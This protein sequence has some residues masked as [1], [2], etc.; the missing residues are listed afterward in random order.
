MQKWTPVLFAFFVLSAFSSTRTVLAQSVQPAPDRSS[1]LDLLN[2]VN[3]LRASH[4]LPPYR[5]NAILMGITQTQADYLASS[6]LITH[7]GADG[8][9]PYQRALAAGY[10]L[11]GDVS[12][13][14]YYSENVAAATNMTAADAVTMWMGDAPHQNTMLSTTYQDAGVGMAVS[15]NIYYYALD[16]GLSTGGTAAPYIPPTQSV[17]AS[18]TPGGATSTQGG[19]ATI[20]YVVKSGDTLYGIAQTWGMSVDAILQKN[21]LT[22]SSIIYPGQKLLIPVNATLT[23]S[24]GPISAATLIPTAAP[25]ETPMGV[26]SLMPSSTPPTSDPST[27]TTNPMIGVIV[28]SLG[29]LLLIVTGLLVFNRARSGK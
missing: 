24:P 11:A 14:G 27:K 16:A 21:N 15:G 12:L 23:P 4:G 17:Q 2:A 6:G 18:L 28:I 8:S 19:G 7:I 13:G 29:I 25:T 1:A 3:A 20:T 9:K 10:P 26:P 5:A 22:L